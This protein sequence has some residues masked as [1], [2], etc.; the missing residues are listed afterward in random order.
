[1]KLESILRKLVA[2][3]NRKAPAEL[4]ENENYNIELLEQRIMYSA[5][6][7]GAALGADGFDLSLIHI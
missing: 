5:T 2:Y 7:H 1:M 6:Q 3:A 4:T